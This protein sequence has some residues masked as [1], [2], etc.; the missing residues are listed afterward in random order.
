MQLFYGPL[1]G[2]TR[3]SWYQKKH[4][5]THLSR[6]SS[7]LY[8]LLPSTMI[9]GMLP[10]QF[11][12][13]TIFCTTSLQVLFGLPLDLESST[14]YCI[15]L[16][17]QS[18][19][20]FLQHTPIPLQPVCCSTKS[21]STLLDTVMCLVGRKILLNRSNSLNVTFILISAGWSA[22]SFSFWQ[23]RSHFHVVYYFAHNCC[24]TSLY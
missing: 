2:T 24:T 6:S 15:H 23:A 1:S 16:F 9:H 12:C 3:V 10:I 22:T 18:V 19:S 17:T 21:L 5:P 4:S 8:Q 11:T 7:N 20:F 14:S 13:L